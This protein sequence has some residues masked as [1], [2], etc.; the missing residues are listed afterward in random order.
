MEKS[1]ILPILPSLALTS[2]HVLQ[3]RRFK[4]N[5]ARAHSDGQLGGR[6]RKSGSSLLHP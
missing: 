3:I 4:A 5:V 1:P 6:T 2:Q